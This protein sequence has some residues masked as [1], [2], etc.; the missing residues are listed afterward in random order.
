MFNDLKSL[1]IKISLD[2]FGTEYSSLAYIKQMPI[3]KI[4]IA[5]PFVQSIGLNKKDEAII[6]T[7]VSLGENLDVD[8]IAEGVETKEQVEFL[9]KENCNF[10]QGYYFSKPI[11]FNELINHLYLNGEKYGQ[12]RNYANPM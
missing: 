11:P 2:D 4:K 6:R 7:I 9:L 1:G 5:M 10:M 3:N 8:I 12:I